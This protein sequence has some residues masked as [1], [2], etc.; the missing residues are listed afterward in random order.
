M[1]GGENKDSYVVRLGF[2]VLRDHARRD[3][4]A[5]KVRQAAC[6]HLLGNPSAVD[7]DGA[8]ANPKFVGNDLVSGC[9]SRDAP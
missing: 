2:G 9:Q 6:L 7:F 3:G 5:H 4:Q 1:S 8:R